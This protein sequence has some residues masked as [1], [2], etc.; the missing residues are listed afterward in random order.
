MM[1]S[2]RIR[3]ERTRVREA[4][5]E[6]AAVEFLE[7]GYQGTTMNKIAARAGFTKGAAYSNFTSKADLLVAACLERLTATTELVGGEVSEIAKASE[8]V[9]DI[10]RRLAQAVIE[11]GPW[12]MALAEVSMVAR[13]DHDAAAAYTVIRETQLAGMRTQLEGLPVRLRG[14]AESS[15]RVLQS[16]ITQ[17]GLERAVVPQ[18]WPDEVIVDVMITLVRGL[19]AE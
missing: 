10:G 14:D 17:L 2:T 16:T 13:R 5:L 12:A 15:A 11:A 19:I 7:H 18:R 8:T 9:D 3:P 6:A 1:S 4:L